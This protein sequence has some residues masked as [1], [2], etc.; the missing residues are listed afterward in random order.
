M[1]VNVSEVRDYVMGARMIA[2]ICWDAPAIYATPNAAY[3]YTAWWSREYFG[4]PASAQAAEAAYNKYFALLDK[5]DTLWTAMVCDSEPDR[6]ALPES[7]GQNAFGIQRGRA[8]A[9]AIARGIVGCRPGR[10]GARGGGTAS[11][12]A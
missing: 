6:P 3:C 10:R 4:G 5:P 11:D 9:V 2:D 1:L 8:G 12:P 7:G